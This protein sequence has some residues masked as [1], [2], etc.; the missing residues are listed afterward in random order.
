VTWKELFP[1]YAVY[2]FEDHETKQT[3]TNGGDYFEIP[4]CDAFGH[5]DD[6]SVL[7]EARS[8]ASVLASYG[9]DRPIDYAKAIDILESHIHSP[10]QGES[11]IQD[12]WQYKLKQ[13]GDTPEA[14]QKLIAEIDRFISDH[15]KDGFGLMSAMNFVAY[16]GWIPQETTDALVK[17][18]EGKYP[19]YDPRLFIFQAKVSSEK[20][21]DKRIALQWEL[22]EK[23]PNSHEADNALNQLASE[24]K[25][26]SQREKIYEQLRAKHPEDPFQPFNLATLYSEAN[27]KLSEALSLV[28]EAERLLDANQQDKNAKIHYFESTIKQNKLR[29]AL[30]RRHSAA[31]WKTCAI[32]CCLAVDQEQ[33]RL[34]LYLLLTGQG[35]GGERPE[36][37]RG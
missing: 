15:A 27:K 8:Y 20:N 34:G 16:Q 3:D 23:Y 21:K 25:E 31:D 1:K 24:V 6:F 5:R 12:I 9:V 14:R 26:L 7:A 19:N 4:F 33:L 29:F 11:F 2:W 28:D 22:V 35:A 30:T 36:A 17:A 37:Q 32:A 10:H 18:L 13:A